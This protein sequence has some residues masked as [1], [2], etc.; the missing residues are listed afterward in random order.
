MG[1]WPA[2]SAVVVNKETLTDRVGERGCYADPDAAGSELRQKGVAR[3]HCAAVRTLVL[4]CALMDIALY[5]AAA[6][7]A[8]ASVTAM[9][10]APGGATAERA[11]LRVQMG[12]ASSYSAT[13]YACI[14]QTTGALTA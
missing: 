14:T 3:W 6:A 2:R 13:T 7:E 5:A 8:C 4:L 9:L 11:R 12:A 1:T 10:S